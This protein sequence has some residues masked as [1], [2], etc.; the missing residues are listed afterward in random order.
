M[1]SKTVISEFEV[2][3]ASLIFLLERG[4]IPYQFSIPKGK[5]IDSK[6]CEKQ[7]LDI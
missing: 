3:K 6:D 4:V 1:N 5:D 7:I 2:L